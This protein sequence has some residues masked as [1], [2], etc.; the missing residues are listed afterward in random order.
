MTNSL[1][2]IYA[3]RV[4][5]LS[6]KACEKIIYNIV[7]F[8]HLREKTYIDNEGYEKTWDSASRFWE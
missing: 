1:Q 7:A 4:E 3:N 8:Y 6:L 5:E 2:I